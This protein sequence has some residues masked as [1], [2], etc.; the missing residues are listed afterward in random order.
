M[1]DSLLFSIKLS[2]SEYLSCRKN[3]TAGLVG[4]G[5]AAPIGQ[6][7][8][9][10]LTVLYDVRQHELAPYGPYPFLRG[11]FNLGF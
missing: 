2:I 1:S 10:V 3:I 5:F 9:L 4:I 11:G 8:I 7:S 6:Q